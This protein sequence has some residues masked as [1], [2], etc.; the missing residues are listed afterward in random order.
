MSSDLY[1]RLLGCGTPARGQGPGHRISPVM[2]E[3]AM[4][5]QIVPAS[6]QRLC[7]VRKGTRPDLTADADLQF[8]RGDL[9]ES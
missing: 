8:H 1:R 3:M 2:L 7:P 5:L 9:R 6:V 4:N